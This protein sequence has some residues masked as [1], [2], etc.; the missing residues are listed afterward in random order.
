MN[1]IARRDRPGPALVMAVASTIACG[2]QIIGLT[3]YVQRMPD[4]TTGMVVFT[5][6][7]CAFG[8]GAIANYIRWA[9]L[10]RKQ[11]GPLA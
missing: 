10:R 3:R 5:V 1:P 2:L 7:A 8:V 4:D 6:A 11:R 9:L